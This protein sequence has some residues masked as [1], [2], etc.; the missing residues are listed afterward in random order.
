MYHLWEAITIIFQ[1][2]RKVC[3]AVKSGVREFSATGFKVV[4]G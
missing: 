4:T 2:T 1:A 3:G